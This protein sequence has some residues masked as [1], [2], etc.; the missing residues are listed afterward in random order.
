MNQ[1]T[2]KT[3]LDRRAIAL[4]L[5]EG[6]LLFLIVYGFLNLGAGTPDDDSLLFRPV[7]DAAE[8]AYVSRAFALGKNPLLPVVNELHPSRFSPVHPFLVSLW[9]RLHS[10]NFDAIFQWSLVAL[11][12]A[13]LF[14]YLLLMLSGAPFFVRV[15][16]AY[17]ILYSPLLLSVS[18]RILQEPTIFLLFSPACAAWF[19]GMLL[20]QIPEKARIVRGSARIF[21]SYVLFL[22]SGLFCGALLCI[23]ITLAPL[24]LLLALHALRA[25]P[26][27]KTPKP[28]L[29]F[30]LGHLI[31]LISVLLYMKTL[32]GIF[33]LQGYYHWM[34]DYKPFAWANALTPPV[35]HRNGIPNYLLL[36]RTLLGIQKT[37]VVQGWLSMSL[38]FFFGIL[39]FLIP[40]Q[41]GSEEKSAK[42]HFCTFRSLLLF[43]FLF[44]IS[45]IL[46]HLFYFFFDERFFILSL[47]VIV[48]C[49]V[50]GWWESFRFLY[51]AGKT[52]KILILI[53]AI[54][55]GIIIAGGP[56]FLRGYG[57]LS[58]YKAS[59]PSSSPGRRE[60]MIH[61]GYGALIR[62]LACPLFV[63]KLPVLNARL[64][65]DL[66]ESP[67]PIAPLSRES[68][69]YFEGHTVQFLWYKVGPAAGYLDDASIW[70]GRP[71]DCYLF[72]PESDGIR[73]DYL[74]SLLD[75]YG[76]LAIYFP[77]WRAKELAGFFSSLKD[78]GWE[79]KNLARSGGWNLLLVTKNERR[80]AP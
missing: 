61:A 7:P 44:G 51:R 3:G 73:R 63:D 26:P 43:L 48:L 37:I 57:V 13:M 16:I 49:G 46:I 14:L 65:L 21:C 32:A 66:G 41:R 64:L 4:L 60:S 76:K 72:D 71:P 30:L 1:K 42:E 9:I 19:G 8:Q 70:R 78:P 25:L 75:H 79:I 35:N 53:A 27:K 50:F 45:Q 34:P 29:A 22:L 68:N 77:S 6:A 59:K 23:R 55:C 69:L 15:L 54:L 58:G 38:L 2:E 10:G 18:R 5:A 33:S 24:S 11:L 40:Q 56:D 12:L 31:V 62:P 67:F 28:L 17:L 52:K 20:S 74:V 36:A 47:P 39:G 80:P